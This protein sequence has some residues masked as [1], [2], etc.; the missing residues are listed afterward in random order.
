[1]YL[2]VR[3]RSIRTFL[4]YSSHYLKTTPLSR[5]VGPYPL[6]GCRDN[7]VLC[8]SKNDGKLRD[9]LVALGKVIHEDNVGVASDIPTG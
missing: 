8:S 6:R 2:Q 7:E 1:L 5:H 9:V 3:K 4:V